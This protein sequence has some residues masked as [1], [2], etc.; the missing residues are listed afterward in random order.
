MTISVK[1]E[2]QVSLP[3]SMRDELV[4][5]ALKDVRAGDGE[6][7]PFADCEI[8]DVELEISWGTAQQFYYKL[9]YLGDLDA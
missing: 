8:D 5:T 4:R 9:E 1:A 7:G 3:D 2:G 6:S